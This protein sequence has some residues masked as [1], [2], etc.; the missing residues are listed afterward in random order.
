MKGL[1]A[2]T[3][4]ALGFAA[5]PAGPPVFTD[6]TTAAGIKFRHVNGAS[7]KKFLPETLGSGCAFLD[8]D[9]DGWQDILLINSTH[10]PSQPG[11]TGYPA[12]YHNNKNGSLV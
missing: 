10:I 4:I 3:L 1:V 12:L 5:A 8:Y 11:P 6:V 9:N 2:A 7:G